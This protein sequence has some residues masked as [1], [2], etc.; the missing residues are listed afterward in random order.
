MAVIII[1]QGEDPE[2]WKTALEAELPELEFRVWPRDTRPAEDIDVAGT[3]I[4]AP[5]QR[6]LPR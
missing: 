6:G 2:G 4:P 1:C 5:P 3:H